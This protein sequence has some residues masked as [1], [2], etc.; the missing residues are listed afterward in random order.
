[1]KQYE[2]QLPKRCRIDSVTIRETFGTDEDEAVLAAENSGADPK[3]ELVSLSIVAV[4]G[5]PCLPGNSGFDKWPTKT[6]SVVKALFDRVNDYEGQ[7]LKPLIEDAEENHTEVVDDR[8]RTR[9]AFPEGCGLNYV[10]LQEMMEPDERAASAA[11][12]DVTEEM[13]RRCVVETDRFGGSLTLENLK[14]LNTKT[15]NVLSVY[16][17][18]MNFVSEEELAPLAMAAE[19]AQEAMATVPNASAEPS[20]AESSPS[21]SGSP[22]IVDADSTSPSESSVALAE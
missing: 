9:Y 12:K 15:R 3:A 14:A 17:S 2:Y 18:G 1:M 4:N 16:W 19:A 21:G 22:A 7:D 8:L 13:I 11:G 5:T 10:V 6:R 20:A